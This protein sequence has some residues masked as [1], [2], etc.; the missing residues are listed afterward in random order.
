MF[1]HYLSLTKP[2]I[3][4]GN[5]IAAAAGFLL[6]AKGQIDWPLFIATMSGVILIVGSGCTFNNYIDR[7]I[8]GKMQRTKNRVLVTGRLPVSNAL[9]FASLLG[10]IGF[11][12]MYQFS[13]LYALGFGV[14]GFV[15][16][17]GFYSL[18]YKRT[19]VFST[20]IGSISGACPPVMGYVAVTGQVDSGALIL[21]VAFCLWQ[22][23]HSYAIAIYRFNDY[24]QAK[25]PVLPIKEGIK[26]ARYHIIVYIIAFVLVSLMLTH[27]NYVGF[28]YAAVMTILG[29]YWAY[30]AMIEYNETNQ[31]A[32]G[33]KMF[34]LSIITI[35]C[36]S[37][38]ISTDFV[39]ASPSVIT[40]S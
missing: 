14:L 21:L 34:I 3:I 11:G 4:F 7:D 17:V 16:Y 26:A 37:M 5:L 13:N 2:G 18:M 39:A 1:K 20:A 25:I 40:S 19:S 28:L 23:P 12:L 36:F 15:V 38:L 9:M 31:Q 32:W 27:Q 35:C 24:Q 29:G 6:A 33:K 22:I 30:I 8:D 10:V